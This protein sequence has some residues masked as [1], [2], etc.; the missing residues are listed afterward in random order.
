VQLW[1]RAGR[2]P[3]NRDVACG[4]DAAN[5]L[6]VLAAGAQQS[7]RPITQPLVGVET[8]FRLR[9]TIGGT[10]ANVLCRLTIGSETVTTFTSTILEP[11]T[12]GFASKHADLRIDS[13]VVDTN[14]SPVAFRY[15]S[16]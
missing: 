12:W 13:L 16:H 7:P 15:S 6:Y 8:P 3:S 5:N 14:D 2:E 9:A 1:L 10:N 11:G 4:I